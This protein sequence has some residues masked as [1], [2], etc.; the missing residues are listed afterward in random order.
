MVPVGAY[1]AVADW[2]QESARLP[3]KLEAA[4]RLREYGRLSPVLYPSPAQAAGEIVN[5]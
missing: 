3:D 2:I 5:Y 4:T 1:A